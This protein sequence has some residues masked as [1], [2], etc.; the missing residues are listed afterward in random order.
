MNIIKVANQKELD[1]ALKNKK[2]DDEIWLIGN[3]TFEISG[4]SSVR[5]YESSSVRA[6]KNVAVIIESKNVKCQGGHKIIITLP[7]NL[8]EWIKDYEATKINQNSLILYKAVDN[9]FEST[10]KF[11]YLP[12]TTVVAPDW[13][14]GKLE[15]GKGLHFCATPAECVYFFPEATKFVACRVNLKDLSFYK[16]GEYPSKVKAKQCKVLYECDIDGKKI[17]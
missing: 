3:E 6:R 16:D 7:K 9:D 1:E 8:N 5:A 17:A 10:Y 15:C 14:N 4:S 13:D 2:I 11:E 12:K